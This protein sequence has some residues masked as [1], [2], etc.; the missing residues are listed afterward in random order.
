MVKLEHIWYNKPK[1]IHK[2]VMYSCYIHYSHMR[3]QSNKAAYVYLV[4]LKMSLHSSIALN[5]LVV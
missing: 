4:N 1:A 5:Q 2:I 3:T